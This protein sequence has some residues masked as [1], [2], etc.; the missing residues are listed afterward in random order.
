MTQALGQEFSS[1][2]FVLSHCYSIEE[3]YDSHRRII[4]G[5]KGQAIGPR[6]NSW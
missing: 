4:K 5:Q 6:L 2:C 1:H 3:A